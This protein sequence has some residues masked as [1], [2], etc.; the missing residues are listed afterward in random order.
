MTTLSYD[1]VVA[2][3]GHRTGVSWPLL[4]AAITFI[5]LLTRGG[6]L[7]D[8]DTY[9][10]IVAGRWMF[11]HFAIPTVDPFSYT[12]AGAPWTAHEWLSEIVFAAAFFLGGWSAVIGVAA[13]A[14]ATALAILTR[15]LLRHLEP[16][17]AVVFVAMAFSLSAQHLLA[18]PHTLAAPLL[19]FWVVALLRAREASRAPPLWVALLMVVWANL[20]GSFAFG[21]VLGAVIGAEA[22]RRAKVHAYAL[23][24]GRPWV[25]KS[26]RGTVGRDVTDPLCQNL[27]LAANGF[28]E[29]ARNGDLATF[30]D[31]IERNGS[32]NYLAADTLAKGEAV[33]V[34]SGIQTPSP[35]LSEMRVLLRHATVAARR[36]S[37]GQMFT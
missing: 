15:Y 9:W 24:V 1:G 25:F 13:A 5:V 26:F 4:V 14:F 8:G 3:T 27:H 20:H 37:I 31:R 22:I 34:A 19:V 29:I 18:R 2:T 28:E 12:M 36:P 32:V 23:L 11:Q 35:P 30:G 7:A 10:H 33:S 17:Y 6:L 21:L 16:L